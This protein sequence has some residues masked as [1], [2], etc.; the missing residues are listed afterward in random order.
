M[1]KL[2]K[3]NY[4][5]MA[6]RLGGLF[7]DDEMVIGIILLERSVRFDP[8]TFTKTVL[9]EFIQQDRVI[10]TVKI[11]TVEDINVAESY[12]DLSIGESIQNHQGI[13]KWNIQFYKGGK[14]QNELQKLN[15]S[16][17]YSIM[18][19]LKDDKVLAQ[20]NK[21]GS[22]QGF[23][24]KLFTG[25]RNIKTGAE[26]GGST[27]RVDLTLIGMSFWQE[28]SVLFTDDT[29]DF[30]QLQPIEAVDVVVPILEAGDTSTT[31]KITRAGSNAP[32]IGLTDK[33]NWKLVRNG[34]P[35]AI[36]AITSQGENY[37]FTHAA[38]VAAQEIKFVTNMTGYPI[39]V[40]DNGYFVAESNAKKVV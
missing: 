15:K 38:L 26:G 10:G 23:E 32:M 37:T 4:G 21:D 12:T 20:Q 24:C 25:I 40:L 18:F 5:N 30:R 29:I 35:E 11:D 17:A 3:C 6:A 31:V 34:V 19:V 8:A 33:D 39:Y 22:I 2:A 7:C 16:E 1:L 13:K 14:F 27:L 28:S 9:D 36:T